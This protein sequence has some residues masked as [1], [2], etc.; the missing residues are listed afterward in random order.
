MEQKK[1]GEHGFGSQGFVTM[2]TS[3]F[4]YGL[5]SKL[6]FGKRTCVYMYVFV[7]VCVRVRVC[8]CM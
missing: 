7:C 5:G 2:A 8:V 3:V 6:I 1:P 4:T